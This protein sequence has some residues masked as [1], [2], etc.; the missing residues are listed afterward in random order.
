MSCLAAITHPAIE[1]PA[2][3]LETQA[4]LL[5]ASKRAQA[6]HDQLLTRE[7][8][9][10]EPPSPVETLPPA[11]IEQD[12][13]P[14]PS[15]WMLAQQLEDLCLDKISTVIILLR[16]NTSSVPRGGWF[17]DRC[18][19]VSKHGSLTETIAALNPKLPTVSPKVA[20]A[21]LNRGDLGTLVDQTVSETALDLRTQMVDSTLEQEINLAIAEYGGDLTQFGGSRTFARVLAVM[22][23]D[24][25]D[26]PDSP[27]PTTYDV[28]DRIWPQPAEP[29]SEVTY[30]VS[31]GPATDTPI[32]ARKLRKG[33]H[34]HPQIR[35]ATDQAILDALDDLHLTCMDQTVG[36]EK[37]L[38]IL[39]V[40]HDGFTHLASRLRALAQQ[41]C[42]W[43]IPVPIFQSLID[44]CEECN[45]AGL[46]TG[47][48][49]RGLLQQPARPRYMCEERA[50]GRPLHKTEGTAD[51]LINFC[52]TQLLPRDHKSTY[53]VDKGSPLIS[54][55]FQAYVQSQNARIH[56][57][58]TGEHGGNGRIERLVITA[59]EYM[60][61]ALGV[62]LEHE[63][64]QMFPE[65]ISNYIATHSAV[66][67]NS[68]YTLKTDRIYPHSTD[69]VVEAILDEALGC[70]EPT[71]S[72]R[73]EPL[74]RNL[75]ALEVV[76]RAEGAQKQSADYSR[77][78]AP[79]FA[80]DRELMYTPMAPPQH[81]LWLGPATV[82]AHVAPVMHYI[83]D[84]E[85]QKEYRLYVKNLS[86]YR[87]PLGR[88]EHRPMGRVAASAY[89]GWLCFSYPFAD[90]DNEHKRQDIAALRTSIPA[91][92]FLNG[93][94]DAW[95]TW[96][97]LAAKIGASSCG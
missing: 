56:P 64:R 21:T 70:A 5:A 35:F 25:V 95:Q 45:W 72:L 49:A 76:A 9:E 57:A 30:T 67:N 37:V 73:Q 29:L 62:G 31:D 46:P 8:P 48:T 17:N 32:H 13:E 43:N 6:L 39:W 88:P 12:P 11:G 18:H 84:A 4:E 44:T 33:A 87:V 60:K 58:S 52:N 34:R 69:P 51:A 86:A 82:L 23:R 19:E 89:G 47:P 10:P 93:C 53:V 7:A 55:E 74:D 66:I 90:D 92:R 28:V 79:M 20:G 59:L 77:I 15:N 65:F 80:I 42:A 38:Q 54:D 63:W 96:S 36:A 75:Q 3:P 27:E 26:E 68:P 22:S 50:F 94:S 81:K 61:R 83:S 97:D 16:Y 85:L 78:D 1:P 91:M 14:F 24:T 41:K 71:V 2:L 40:W